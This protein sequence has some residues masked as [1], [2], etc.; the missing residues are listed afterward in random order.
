RSG[1]DDTAETTTKRGSQSEPRRSRRA[2]GGA[3]GGTRTPTGYPTRPSNVRVCQFRHFGVARMMPRA[4]RRC[5]GDGGAPRG[6][7]RPIGAPPGG[8]A[9]RPSLAFTELRVERLAE[10]LAAKVEGEDHH[11]DGGAR[12]EGQ[13]GG[14]EDEPLAV[15]QDVAPGRVGG[16][17]AEAQEREARLR[18]DGPRDPQ[19]RGDE[20]GP[21]GGGDQG[22]QGQAAGR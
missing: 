3:E 8:P 2:E 17:D 5:Q 19:G 9:V 10:P 11:E 4:A 13:P 12:D 14:V 6:S 7:R 20:D 18:Q 1:S 21:D 15:G 22:A 16:R